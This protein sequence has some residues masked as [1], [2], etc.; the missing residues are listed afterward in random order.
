LIPLCAV[1]ALTSF[2]KTAAR[3][4][5]RRASPRRPTPGQ[6]QGRRATKDDAA[7]AKDAAIVAIDKFI[8]SNTP[9]KKPDDWRMSLA[10]PPKLTFTKDAQY[11][12]R[13]KTNKGAISIRLMPNVAPM[14]VSNTIYLARL[15][16]YDSLKF[17]R[18]ITGFMAQ[19][20][21]PLGTGSGGPGYKFDGELDP[22]VK[23]DNPGTLSMANG[24]PGTDGSQFFLTFASAHHLDGK[25][26]IFG[27]VIAG[28]ETLKALEACGS[29]SGATSE[30]LIIEQTWIVVVPSTREPSPPT[31]PGPPRIRRRRAESRPDRARGRR[32]LVIHP[33]VKRGRSS[34][35]AHY[36]TFARALA[37]AG[38][39]DVKGFADPT[40]VTCCRRP[41]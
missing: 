1:L 20:G 26:T 28:M 22:N 39:T 4:R 18:V 5:D 21:C 17:H 12:W 25:H 40:A 14:H 11:E 3:N 37:D 33:A 27:Q 16:F 41:G 23:H 9:S 8:A 13:L 10:A 32:P 6:V 34:K 15:G 35:T 24:G 2:A 38:V 36:V 31:R 19:G 29:E 7:T 30:Q